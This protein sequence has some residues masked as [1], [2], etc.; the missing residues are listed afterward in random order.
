MAIICLKCRHQY[1]VTLF[2]FGNVVECDC[3]ASIK[4]DPGKGLILENKNASEDAKKPFAQEK[5]YRNTQQPIIEA[6]FMRRQSNNFII[7]N[8][9]SEQTYVFEHNPNNPWVEG[10]LLTI[11]VESTRTPGKHKVF[12][13]GTV[14]HS[15]ID[16]GA[17]NITPLK[18]H[19]LGLWDPF[20][21]YGDE[22]RDWF[23][24]YL[25]KTY[26]YYEMETVDY[27]YD[28]MPDFDPCIDAMDLFHAGKADK[29][30]R[31]LGAF[32]CRDWRYLDGHNHLGI[33]EERVGNYQKMRKH[34]ELAVK[35]GSLT[36][37]RKLRR[38][39]L[40]WDIVDPKIRIVC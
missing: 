12:L 4:L 10:E 33:M 9:E 5:Q 24:G 30:K 36:L 31:E 27:Y 25:D 20:E 28:E 17:L 8:I 26:R 38:I 15:V 2:E 13:K 21:H 34:Y 6:I 22:A 16:I 11:L 1:D 37:N 18:L 19:D 7:K 35:I 29:A 40:P 14:I 23:A 39:V 3:G 32:L